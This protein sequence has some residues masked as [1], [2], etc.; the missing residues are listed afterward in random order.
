MKA[1]YA[2]CPI[3]GFTQARETQ[4]GFE[5]MWDVVLRKYASPDRCTVYQ[6][7]TW[8]IN[9]TRR[10]E[11]LQRLEIKHLFIPA[12][13][14]GQAAAM[15]L[16]RRA[17]D[18]DILSVRMALLDPVGRNPLLPRT[19]FFQGLSARSMSPWMKIDIPTTVYRVAWARQY[20]NLPRAHDLKWDKQRTRVAAPLIINATHS[21]IQW[22]P[23]WFDLVDREVDNWLNPPKAVPL[24]SP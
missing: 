3:M 14:H 11:Q 20:V 12:Y 15:E 19:T 21:E 9:V 4:T 24:L 10:L 13:S 6:P 7:E 23:K 17:P 5:K 2:I 22:H 8:K 1:D 18:Y 16:A